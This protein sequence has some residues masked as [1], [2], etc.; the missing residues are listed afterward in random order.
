MTRGVERPRHVVPRSLQPSATNGPSIVMLTSRMP[1]ITPPRNAAAIHR[2]G[3]LRSAMHKAS[4]AAPHS[5]PERIAHDL[6][7]GDPRHRGHEPQRGRGHAAQSGGSRRRSERE[8]PRARDHRERPGRQTGGDGGKEV[9]R[10]NRIAHGRR[11]QFPEPHV[12]RV[13][14]PVRAHLGDGV[15]DHA[16][17]EEDGV[18]DVGRRGHR[19]QA[20]CDPD[21]NEAANRGAPSVRG[22]AAEPGNPRRRRDFRLVH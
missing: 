12:H 6:T 11:E 10:E 8:C 9:E 19:E 14:R 4:I 20:D 16:A 18:L 3:P 2:P 15:T 13:A 5:M 17:N 21:H 1:G 22:R 7:S